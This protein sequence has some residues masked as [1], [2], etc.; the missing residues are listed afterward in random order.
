MGWENSEEFKSAALCKCTL[1]VSPII[2]CWIEQLIC[3]T[4]LSFVFQLIFWYYIKRTLLSS[5]HYSSL[6][7]L[8]KKIYYSIKNIFFFIL[9]MWKN[10]QYP[11]KNYLK[12][13]LNKAKNRNKSEN[14]CYLKWFIKLLLNCKCFCT[15]FFN[16]QFSL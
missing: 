2:L 14:I 12:R 15:K 11:Y 3:K 1:S 7:Q 10:H 13:I 4:S 5:F 9:W 6:L 8:K 16:C